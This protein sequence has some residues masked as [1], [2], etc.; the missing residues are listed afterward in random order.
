MGFASTVG[1]VTRIQRFGSAASLDSHL[2]GP[3]LDGVYRRRCL[4]EHWRTL[5]TAPG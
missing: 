3:A 4:D 5:G 1:A 2:H